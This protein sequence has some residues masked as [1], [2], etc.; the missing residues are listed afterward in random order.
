MNRA[1]WD[2][3]PI[4]SRILDKLEQ[5]SDDLE[6]YPNFTETFCSVDGY[7]IR[8]WFESSVK[9]NCPPAVDASFDRNNQPSMI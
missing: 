8:Y 6:Q 2:G 9:S 7:T 5:L 4:E 1:L 3:L